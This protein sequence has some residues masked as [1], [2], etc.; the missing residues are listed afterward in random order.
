MTWINLILG[1][2]SLV[3]CVMWLTERELR[4]HHE[5][6]KDFWAESSTEHLGAFLDARKRIEYLERHVPSCVGLKEGKN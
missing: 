1:S 3:F 6:W 2:L 4:K 5:E